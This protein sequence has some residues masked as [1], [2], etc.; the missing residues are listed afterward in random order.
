MNRVTSITT[1][2][3]AEAAVEACKALREGELTVKSLQEWF[4][5]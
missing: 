3:A 4:A 2:A 1:L 5:R